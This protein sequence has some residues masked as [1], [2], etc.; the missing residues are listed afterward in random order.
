M[1]YRIWICIRGFTSHRSLFPFPSIHL[2][3]GIVMIWCFLDRVL[4][5]IRRSCSQLFHEKEV[6]SAPFSQNTWFLVINGLVKHAFVG[7]DA[8]KM[9]WEYFC[10]CWNI[11]CPGST[12]SENV[13]YMLV[14]PL[15]TQTQNECKSSENHFRSR[16]FQNR[17]EVEPDEFSLS[18]MIPPLFS[19]LLTTPRGIRASKKVT[20]SSS[21]ISPGC[22]Q[23]IWT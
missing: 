2:S 19:C 14:A 18:W 8:D 23:W 7:S 13:S 10:M 22:L 1:C 16:C 15:Y 6:I 11:L 4:R 21:R 9:M 12:V 17:G 5:L 20:E 3:L